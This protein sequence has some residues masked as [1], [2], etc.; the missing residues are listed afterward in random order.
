MK[1]MLNAA[2]WQLHFKISNITDLGTKHDN[3]VVMLATASEQCTV[4]VN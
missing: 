1:Q 2:E 4:L 3:E